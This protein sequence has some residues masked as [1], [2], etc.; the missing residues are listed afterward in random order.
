M[1]YHRLHSIVKWRVSPHLRR[2]RPSSGWPG[3]ATPGAVPKTALA[4]VPAVRQTTRIA[5]KYLLDNTLAPLTF[6]WGFLEASVDAVSHRYA[7]WQRTILHRVRVTAIDLPLADALQQLEPLDMGSQRVLFLST[8]TRWTACFDNGATGGNPST[9][10]GELSRQLRCQGVACGCIP[11][12]LTRSAAATQGTWGAVKFTLFGPEQ[13]DFLNVERA[14]SVI[15]DVRGWEFKAI[16]RPQPF[17]R[18]ERY[19]ARRIADRFTSEMLEEY[20]GALGIQLFDENFY[21]GA[22]V[23]THAHPWFL[24]RLATMTLAEARARLG[25]NEPTRREGRSSQPLDDEET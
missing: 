21:G 14:V 17:E 11:N 25:L 8:K 1:E 22:G 23:I 24:P 19:A 18:P 7:R 15:N 3:P 2:S 20:C 6:S 16:G 12:T 10:V 4:A 9:I 13:R 5:V